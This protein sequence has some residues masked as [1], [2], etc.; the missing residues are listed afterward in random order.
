MESQQN[1]NHENA[2]YPTENIVKNA[3]GEMFTT[4]LII[5]QAFEKDHKNVLRDIENLEC[6]EEFRR[7]NF[8]HTPYVHP[9]N[10]QTYP[11]YRIT[12][13]GFAF[14]AMGFTGKKAAAWKEKFLEAFNAMEK[15]LLGRSIEVPAIEADD[16]WK[17]RYVL[18]LKGFTAY[19][20][21]V[22]KMPYIAAE[23]ALCTHLGIDRIED[24]VEVIDGKRITNNALSFLHKVSKRPTKDTTTKKATENDYIILR[25]MLMACSQ[26]KYTRDLDF[27][28]HFYKETGVMP[29]EIKEL[30]EHDAQKMIT[31]A[32]CL[33]HE[34]FRYTIDHIDFYESK[35][36][37]E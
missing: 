20:A 32:S 34:V 5:A 37:V 19:W 18:F 14:L 9:Q 26:L 31:Y 27:D 15:Q 23:M 16:V 17:K 13:D 7:L 28:N 24:A 36:V 25:H 1:Q 2:L 10:G 6:S 29:M 11:A 12:R 21:F 35:E 33:L 22:D 4:S 30:C 8:E 3:D